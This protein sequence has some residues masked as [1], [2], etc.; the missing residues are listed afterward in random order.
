MV[1]LMLLLLLLLS[2]LLSCKSGPGIKTGRGF[3]SLKI[4][5]WIAQAKVV[6]IALLDV[7]V[8]LEHVEN[9]LRVFCVVLFCYG[10]G[11]EEACPLFG[12]PGECAGNWIEA[13]MHLV[14]KVSGRGDAH[15]WGSAVNVVHPV[16]AYIEIGLD[17][18]MT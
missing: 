16:T 1:L 14:H 17:E 7:G 2:R 3:S 12:K 11:S 18:G 15:E 10:R 5:G 6:S 4:H 9:S 8:E 13:Y